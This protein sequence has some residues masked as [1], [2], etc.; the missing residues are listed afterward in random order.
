VFVP[1]WRLRAA[2]VLLL[3][4]GLAER[5]EVAAGYWEVVRRA[6]SAPATALS[7]TH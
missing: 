7:R 3:A 2:H 1:C 4:R 6:T 5:M